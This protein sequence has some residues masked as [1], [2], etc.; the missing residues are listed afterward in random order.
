MSPAPDSSHYSYSFYSDPATAQE[1]DQS[2]FGGQIGQLVALAQ[3][4]VIDEFLVDLHGLTALDV[5][6][7]TGR[8][9][10]A[11]ARLG[12]SVTAVDV[13]EQMLRV[14]RSHAEAASLPVTFVPGDANSLEFADQS[15]D[16]VISL[17]MLMHTPNWKRCLGEMCRVSRRRVVFDY[18][19]LVSAPAVQMLLRRLARLAGR[20]V[21]TYHVI[22]TPAARSVL[23]AHEFQVARFHRQF[24]L[25]IAL[26]KLVGSRRFTQLSES[27][28]AAVGLLHV[29]GSPV[30]IMAERC[31]GLA[32]P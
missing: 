5:G 31:P 16:L 1:F 21:E 6:S 15:F 28:L 30:T 17:R 2:R 27:A 22:S 14:A 20:R 26:H 4:Q 29:L 10:L 23:R 11:L 12:A 3:E 7:G 13:S 19:P 24:V 9:A 18:P 25:P 8:A 32:H